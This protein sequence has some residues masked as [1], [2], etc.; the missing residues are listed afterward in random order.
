ML[1]CLTLASVWLQTDNAKVSNPLRHDSLDIF[2]ERN[3]TIIYNKV[4][5][6]GCF[7][8][9]QIRNIDERHVFIKCPRNDEE[10]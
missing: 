1:L 8:Y 5:I 9:G 7:R 4:R 3:E 10:I 2:S 6:K